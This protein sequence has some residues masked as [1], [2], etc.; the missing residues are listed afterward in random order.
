MSHD[1]EINGRA[2]K[3]RPLKL[4]QALKVEAILTGSLFPAIGSIAAGRISAGVLS[5]VYEIE[6]IVDI[7]AESCQVDWQGKDVPLAKFLDLVFELKNVDLLLW[8]AQCVEVQFADFFAETG[9][10]QLKDLGNRF[11]SLLGLTGESGAS[12]Q[13]TDS[14]TA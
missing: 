11:T 5:G 2:F 10:Q 6:T 12:Q 4:K 9:R 7:F 13:A 1:F 8:L 14:P 3:L